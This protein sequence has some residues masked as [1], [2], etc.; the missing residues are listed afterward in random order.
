MY[1]LVTSLILL[2]VLFGLWTTEPGI[3]AWLGLGATGRAAASMDAILQIAIWLVGA[4]ATIFAVNRLFWDRVVARLIGRS[5][6]NL[7]KNAF[8]AIILI[9]ATIGIVGGVFDRDVT[10]IWATSGALGLVLGFALRS[11]IQDV[12]SGIAI[13]LDGSIRPG[14]WVRLHHR[15]FKNEQ[16]GQLLEINW[17]TSRI[18]LEDDNV[19]VVPNGLMATMA[20]TDYASNDH[21]TRFEVKVALDYAVPTERAVR[22]LK[23]GAIG[24]CGSGGVVPVP[25]PHVLVGETSDVGVT[26]RIRYWGQ[27]TAH[28]P[29]QMANA[30]L[31]SVLKHAHKAGLSLSYPKEDVFIAKMPQRQYESDDE[32]DRVEL[33]ARVDL[34]Q[35]ALHRDELYAISETMAV[36]DITAGDTVVEQGGAGDSLFIVA[37]GMLDVEVDSQTG[38]GPVAVGR[39]GAGEVFGEMSLLTG[40]PR[41]ATVRSRTDALL[42]EVRKDGFEAILRS[43]PE[44]AEAVAAI[45]AERR[46]KTLQSLA[47]RSGPERAAEQKRLQGQIL[48]KVTRFF[49]LV[50]EVPAAQSTDRG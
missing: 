23:A 11:M 9:I 35:K 21:V 38:Q 29:A 25:E 28:R 49:R 31:T 1:R 12:F 16:Y 4:F 8:G 50:F 45:V 43:R 41:T 22:V 47:E 39:I 5:V 37:E 32:T 42:Y 48:V 18:Q 34:F 33:L 6:P 24:A 46:M 15:D 30:V 13:N 36:R 10:G 19:I 20:V 40:E 14:D 17:R 27:V 26:Y 7:L 2:A 44:I 3:L